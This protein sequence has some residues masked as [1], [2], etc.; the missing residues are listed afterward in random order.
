MVN[1]ADDCSPYEFNG[2]IDDV[3]LKLENDATLLIEWYKNNY[4]KP[5][6]DN[7]HLLLSEKGADHSVHIDTKYILNSENE[8]ILGVYFDNSLNFNFHV[9]KLCK[10]ARQKLH[11]LARV[12]D[13]MR[14]AQRKV[15]MNAFVTTQFSYCPLLWMCHSRTMHA[16]LNK[17]HERALRMVYR[18]HVSSFQV[19]LEKSGPVTIHHRNLQHL[20]IEI[21]KVLHN[22]S[23]SFMSE[24]FAIK[25]MK[26]N[27]RNQNALIYKKPC[28]SSYGMG[29]ISHL[30]P[31]I[32]DQVPNELKSSKSLNIFK[33]K[34]KKWTPDNC[35]CRL[36]K[37]YIHHVGYI[38]QRF[39]TF[40][41][42]FLFI[43]FYIF[44]RYEVFYLILI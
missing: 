17:I 35:P 27:L 1:F 41:I 36:C 15:I 22:L 9:N 34:I 43:S 28:T 5:N 10:K 32:W 13:Y 26:Y 39:Y 31:K 44:N 21:Y 25:E 18:D 24:L 11:A 14:L 12:S 33:A 3:I 38:D 42:A 23:P 8:K 7:W 4:L 37:L 2:F 29:S 6:P 16:Q 20:A 30:G 40:M 19:L